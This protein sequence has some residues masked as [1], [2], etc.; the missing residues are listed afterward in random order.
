MAREFDAFIS[1]S[2]AA[3]AQLAR[4]LQRGL[5]QFA[6]PIYRVRALRVFRDEST[7]ALT[8]ALWP[9]IRR[10]IE[11]SKYFLLMADPLA[12]ESPWVQ[13]EV[14]A[15]LEL[16]RVDRMILIWTGGEIVWNPDV[17]DFDWRRTNALPR[18]LIG[19]F[20][21][22]PLYLDMRW[23][24]RQEQLSLAHQ[25]FVRG[26]AGIAAAIRGVSLDEIFGEEV[27][28]YRINR[29]IA[30]TGV[31]L[32]ALMALIAG[33][34]W[35][36]EAR[37]RSL[38]VSERKDA[39]VQRQDALAQ[40]AVATE[41]ARVAGVRLAETLHERDL[42]ESEE[43]DR[44][45]T[46][47]L[48]AQQAS[49]AAPEGDPRRDLYRLRMLYLSLLQPQVVHQLDGPIQWVM[50]PQG[51]HWVSLARLPFLDV[52][53]IRTWRRVRQ[54]NVDFEGRVITDV[55]PYVASHGSS[56]EVIVHEAENPGTEATEGIGH[57]V[58]QQWNIETGTHRVLDR[59]IGNAT[60]PYLALTSWGS[61]S[62]AELQQLRRNQPKFSE[63]L[64]GIARQTGRTAAYHATPLPADSP[65][66][67][68][69]DAAS[70][71][72]DLVLATWYE[73]G[74][75]AEAWNQ[76]WQPHSQ[77]G[78]EISIWKWDG[79][80]YRQ[81]SRLKFRGT[82]GGPQAAGFG[83]DGDRTFLWY[84]Q[85]EGTFVVADPDTLRPVRSPVRI[86]G[87]PWARIAGHDLTI[88]ESSGRVSIRNLFRDDQADPMASAV[89]AGLAQGRASIGAGKI[90]DWRGSGELPRLDE[91]PFGLH[92]SASGHRIATTAPDDKLW[93]WERA[94]TDK[95]P[96][97]TLPVRDA[98]RTFLFA[99][100]GCHP[101]Q[102]QFRGDDEIMWC[103]DRPVNSWKDVPLT[104]GSQR[105]PA[106][107][108]WTI[109]RQ[110]LIGPPRPLDLGSHLTPEE[111]LVSFS[112]DGETFLTW[113]YWNDA[114]F[115]HST[116]TGQT[117]GVLRTAARDLPELLGPFFTRAKDWRMNDGQLTGRWS[118]GATVIVT[119]QSITMQTA[120]TKWDIRDPRTTPS[121]E[122]RRLE[123]S[124]QAILAISH[125]GR[126][127]ATQAMFGLLGREKGGNYVRLW[128]AAT[129]APLSPWL[130]HESS[131]DLAFFSE[132]GWLW[133]IGGGQIRRW[134]ADTPDLGSASW[135]DG[136]GEPTSGMRLSTVANVEPIPE[137]E[138]HAARILFRRQ[139]QDAAERGT[140]LL[141]W[142]MRRGRGEE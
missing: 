133:T 97:V 80:V 42:V 89:Q 99:Y 72:G 95:R 93:I 37:A 77:P 100:L 20:G 46:A 139:L 59:E 45:L 131:I 22:E 86:D 111:R 117:L 110:S 91:M 94:A 142:F 90:P 48:Y 101:T 26:V 83:T 3:D 50:L 4:A 16:G 39:L 2:H 129:G 38:A 87:R 63:V 125:S 5:H 68:L 74:D 56:V 84:V 127:I 57:S 126:V 115:L 85:P 119:G 107:P 34:G 76:S 18:Q 58:D 118:A 106:E 121:A 23:A 51:P 75:H 65:E 24:K 123:V 109:K 40:R 128:D 13:K 33:W 36:L 32:L 71:S 15:W 35:V 1:Y 30:G 41:Q 124:K 49:T 102:V 60:W 88:V 136:M 103:E 31:A 8:P 61:I 113:D 135:I 130:W 28:Q 105:L 62:L 12:A 19:F 141:T 52:W 55:S 116:Q 69:I 132:D 29:L 73:L 140:G 134:P 9:E 47:L 81:G 64:D 53:D 44:P 54:L 27:R 92:F 25:E 112:A 138:L 114:G 66:A 67:W 21:N 10:A 70:P 108:S 122:N 98:S 104:Q 43:H 17:G 137:S 96:A 82:P 6:K 14:L 79:S 78:D 120:T 11:A 7:L